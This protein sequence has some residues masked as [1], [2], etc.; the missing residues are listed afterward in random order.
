[1]PESS[2]LRIVH[3]F[4]SP[5]GG[6][7]RH[8]RDLIEV[9]AA[10]GHQIGI[11]CDNNTGGEYEE[12]LFKSISRNLSLGLHRIPM[13]RK[14]G[15][16]DIAAFWKAYQGIRK[17]KPDVLHSHGAKGGAYARLIGSMMGFTGSRIA[18]LYC[19]HGGSIHF[20]AKT[21][22]GR[23]YFMMER[24]LERSTD[25]LIF[26]SDY[27]KQGYFNKVGR[28]RCPYSIIHNGLK[29]EEFIPVALNADAADFLFIGM[30]RDLKGPDLFIDALPIIEHS[31][32]KKIS[33]HLVGG[34]PETDR[35][36]ERAKSLGLDDRVKFHPPMPAREAFA[37]ARIVVVPSRAESMPYIVLETIAAAKPLV[38]TNVGSISEIFE[39]DTSELVKPDDANALALAM[40]GLLSNKNAEADALQKSKNLHGQFSSTLMAEAVNAA[41][42]ATIRH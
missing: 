2:S 23:I 38:V 18:R 33:A 41:Y 40:V 22:S 32:G 27:E 16:S 13:Q 35:Y 9:Q 24:F 28:P 20:D 26:V 31:L 34:G 4:R 42:K 17:L 30:M 37:K 19:P 5:V 14:I 6:I 7:F 12:A 29:D 11:L 3:C 25:R 10:Q 36:I 15:I 1:M 21:I 39:D 8:V